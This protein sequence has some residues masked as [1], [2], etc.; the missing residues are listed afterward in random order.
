[1]QTRGLARTA[2]ISIYVHLA[3]VAICV[4]LSLADRGLFLSHEAS[5]IAMNLVYPFQ[6]PIVL[7]WILCPIISTVAAYESKC[8]PAQFLF[9][10]LAEGILMCSQIM[11]LGPAC[12]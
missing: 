7:A 4:T 11:A 1:M 3:I 12:S 2:R 6:V 10:I 9:V 8:S 5:T